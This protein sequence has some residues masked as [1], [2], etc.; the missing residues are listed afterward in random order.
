[1]ART[2]NTTKY[3]IIQSSGSTSEEVASDGR[4]TTQDQD[5]RNM[6]SH[7]S[8][9]PSLPSYDDGGD[10]D[11]GDSDHDDEEEHE[12]G[13]DGNGGHDEHNDCDANRLEHSQT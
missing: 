8:D 3:K 5:V 10:D 4:K 6:A 11:S 1:M 9:I 7:T 12:G 2:K 13:G